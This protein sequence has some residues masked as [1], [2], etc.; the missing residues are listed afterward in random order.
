M[1]KKT[2]GLIEGVE[3]KFVKTDPAVIDALAANTGIPK[4]TIRAMMRYNIFTVS[5]I[6]ELTGLA[7]STIRNYIR[8][9]FVD[10]ELTTNL[11]FC[12]PFLNCNGRG[13]MFILRNEKSEKYLKV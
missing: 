13:P 6:T 2:F 1:E 5:Q 11:D 7:D 3:C 4:E 9:L 8:P 12:Y 10:G